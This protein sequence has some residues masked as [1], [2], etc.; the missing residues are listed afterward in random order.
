[1]HRKAT[2]SKDNKDY[3]MTLE[4]IMR[5]WCNKIPGNVFR[6]TESDSSRGAKEDAG[7]YDFIRDQIFNYHNDYYKQMIYH[8]WESG[9]DDVGS[10]EPHM[11]KRKGQFIDQGVYYARDYVVSNKLQAKKFH[12][13]DSPL[14]P[15]S[16]ESKQLTPKELEHH[17][18]AYL[19]IWY[20]RG[21][22]ILN[23][24]D[25]DLALEAAAYELIRKT[26]PEGSDM[27]NLGQKLALKMHQIYSWCA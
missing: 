4:N 9:K 18:L 8:V 25:R 22:R 21:M 13:E 12:Y 5:T 16:N 2:I 19:D 7:F 3:N 1:M 26:S 15:L 20:R 10:E 17:E 14:P 6:S 27:T 11:K 23:V 24:N